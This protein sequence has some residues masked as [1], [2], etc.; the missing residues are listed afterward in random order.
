MVKGDRVESR[1]TGVV[2]T[3]KE[4]EVDSVLVSWD[5]WSMFWIS[6][7]AVTKVTGK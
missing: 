7:D 4:V 6:K 1:V 2:G 3:V 5:D